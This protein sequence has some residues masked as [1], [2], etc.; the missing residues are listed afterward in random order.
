LEIVITVFITI[1]LELILNAMVL[2]WFKCIPQRFKGLKHSP[3]GGYVGS[4]ET[5]KRRCCSVKEFV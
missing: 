2:I 1:W 5:L 3:H 4:D